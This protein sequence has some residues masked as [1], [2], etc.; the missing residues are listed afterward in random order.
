ML[1]GYNTNVPYKGKTYHV[2]TEDS[3]SG[4]PMIVTLLYL[5]GAILRSQKTSYDDLVG[6][7]DSEERIRDLMKEQHKSMIKKLISGAFDPGQEEAS[8]GEKSHRQ[9]D[10]PAKE[11]PRDG[12][13][14]GP[15]PLRSYKGKSLD[16]IL[17]EHIA[18]KVKK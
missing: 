9:V 18:R 11:A 8:E 15:D 13:H 17:L 2:Q 1:I 10:T 6:E 12:P 5:E 4:R 14:L 7:P 16:D 3:G